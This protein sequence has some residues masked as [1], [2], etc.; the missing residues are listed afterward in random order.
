MLNTWQ[1]FF[2]LQNRVYSISR[3]DKGNKA[4]GFYRTAIGRDFWFMLHFVFGVF[5]YLSEDQQEVPRKNSDND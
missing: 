3:T 1:I 5:V 4:K 2:H